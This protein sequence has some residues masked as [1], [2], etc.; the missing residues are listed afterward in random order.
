M[1]KLQYIAKIASLPAN[2]SWPA[3]RRTASLPLVYA[4]PSTPSSR[5][6]LEDMDARDEP[7]H[8]EGK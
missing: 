5:I 3:V 2:S 4:R 6:Q 8:D 1:M 7:G